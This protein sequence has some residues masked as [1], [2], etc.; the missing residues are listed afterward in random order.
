MLHIV[1][2]GTGPVA[3]GGPPGRSERATS[4][5]QLGSQHVAALDVGRYISVASAR[6]GALWQRVQSQPRWNSASA[7]DL[8][9]SAKHDEVQQDRQRHEECRDETQR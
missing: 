9:R 7:T 1:T 6:L 8:G 4:P 2:A 3:H 5:R